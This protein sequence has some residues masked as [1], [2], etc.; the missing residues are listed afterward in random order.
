MD[1]T[2]NKRP[3]FQFYPAD[4]LKDP[5]LQICNM[6][7]IGI[8]INILCRMW[9]SKKEG[10]LSGTIEELALLAGSKKSEFNQFLK[11]AKLHNFCDVLHD[12]TKSH[13]NVTLKCRRMNKLFKEREGAKSR[14]RKHR[15]PDVTPD[16]T[17][18]SS[19][20]SSPSK[21]KVVKKNISIFNSALK[22]YPGTK[23][24]V[25]TEFAYFQTNTHTKNDWQDVLP[26]L[27]PAIE[28]QAKQWV[29]EGTLKKFIPHFKT[30]IYN[31][32]WEQVE[33]TQQSDADKQEKERLK[34]LARKDEIRKDYSGFYESK[35][36]DE[37]REMRKDNKY[38]THWWLIDEVGKTKMKG[39]DL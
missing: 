20:S 25:E 38:I 4:W 9:E 34:L 26:K 21:K 36:I 18:H 30:Y 10:L 13:R 5:D 24:G 32:Q 27:E 31:R 8:W 23:R 11:D 39:S 37:L 28:V 7:T 2:M 29:S 22:K 3:S 17:T 6:S 15:S 12:V 1:D 16:V 35:H 14:M 19:S 33:A